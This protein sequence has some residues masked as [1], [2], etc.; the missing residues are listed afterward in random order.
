[1]EFNISG[2]IIFR[3]FEIALGAVFTVLWWMMKEKD[4]ATQ[5]NI[6]KLW[7]EHEKDAKRLQEVELE[8][9]KHHYIKS[10]LDEKF[11]EL[12]IEIKDGL[13]NLSEQLKS[14]T[15]ATIE[16]IKYSKKD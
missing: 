5:R 1:M 9:A 12:K 2:D 13:H 8:I 11:D 15:S 16:L 10:E 4:K 14:F 3:L 7:E 6:E